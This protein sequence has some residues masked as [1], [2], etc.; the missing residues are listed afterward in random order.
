MAHNAPH[1]PL[2]PDAAPDQPEGTRARSWREGIM[3]MSRGQ[4]AEL[5][6]YSI[7]QIERYEARGT[8]NPGFHTYKLACSAVAARISFDWRNATARVTDT[9]VVTLG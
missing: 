8:D 3:G 1:I 7:N 5:T 2:E 6:G 9:R 4:L